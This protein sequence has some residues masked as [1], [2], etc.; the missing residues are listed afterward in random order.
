MK[1]ELTQYDPSYAA[2]A[3]DLCCLGVPEVEIANLLGISVGMLRAWRE[4]Y[5][6]FAYAWDDG[7]Y[8]ADTKVL[9]A[10]YKRAVG[11]DKLVWKDTRHGMMQELIHVEASIPA[12]VFILTN[13]HPDK[14]KTKV[15]HDGPAGGTLLPNNMTD[16]EAARS[17]AFALAQALYNQ[18]RSIEDGNA[19][20]QGQAE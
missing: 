6:E 20:V 5:Q 9:N 16:I 7:L 15:E 11:Y 1:S 13:K 8:H 19:D 2:R 12:C 17:I 10:L 3:R 14:W 18:G 4:R